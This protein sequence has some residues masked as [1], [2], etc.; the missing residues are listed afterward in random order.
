M[1]AAPCGGRLSIRKSKILR[2]TRTIDRRLLLDTLLLLR[3]INAQALAE[4]Q[5]SVASGDRKRDPDHH[6]EA[7]IRKGQ[8][9]AGE[10]IAVESTGAQP[11]HVLAIF[12]PCRCSPLH[13]QEG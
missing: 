12:F 7:M 11:E 1:V 9:K 5:R 2:A 13:V 4:D 3:R 10:E 6:Q 8:M